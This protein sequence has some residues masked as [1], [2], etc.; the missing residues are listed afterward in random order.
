MD[1]SCKNICKGAKG[2]PLISI[3]V[4][5]YNVEK[6]LPRCVDSILAQTLQDFE[7][8]LVDDGSSDASPAICDAYATKDARMVVIHQENAGPAAA[9]NTGLD[10]AKGMWIGFVDSDDWCDPEMYQALYENAV[11]A[12]ADV[13]ACGWRRITSDGTTEYC[14]E[15]E[16]QS[17]NKSDAMI[18]LFKGGTFE[19]YIWNKLIKAA[20]FSEFHV[21]SVPGLMPFEETL[22]VYRI[23]KNSNAVVFSPV[24]YYNYF[25]NPE[26][27]THQ[28][29]LTWKGGLSVLDMMLQSEENPEIRKLI[30][31]KKIEMAS[32]VCYAAVKD[33][34]RAEYSVFAKIAKR[35]MLNVLFCL[36]L[37]LKDRAS[38]FFCLCC[39]PLYIFLQNKYREM[40]RRD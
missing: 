12:G 5:V 37:P 38:R 10:N 40:K 21:R 27:L 39:P 7:C 30:R 24:P 1:I 31:T 6:Y 28:S 36:P 29:P 26:S 19:G 4:P 3:I 9:R 35:Y 13:A 22:L 15:G 25:L 2:M 11:R 8:I 16:P 32:F 18:A 17:F 23:L 33:Y 14:S 20:L 34:K